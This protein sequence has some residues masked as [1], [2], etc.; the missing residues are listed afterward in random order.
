MAETATAFSNEGREIYVNGV[1]REITQEA[2]TEKFQEFGAIEKVRIKR[3]KNASFVFVLFADTAAANAAIEGVNGKDSLEA[4]LARP[5][6]KRRQ[7]RPLGPPSDTQLFVGNLPWSVQE[8][9][10]R[11][12]FSEFDADI[13]ECAIITR[14]QG[15]SRGFGFVSFSTPESASAA[16]SATDNSVYGE[17]DAARTLR[18]QPARQRIVTEKKARA[19]T[20]V[21]AA[22]ANSKNQVNNQV[23]CSQLPKNLTVGHLEGLFVDY[24]VVGK[25]FISKLGGRRGARTRFG[26]VTLASVVEVESAIEDLDGAEYNSE[27]DG[28]TV[29]WVLKVEKARSKKERPRA[30]PLVT[31]DPSFTSRRVFVKGFSS[32]ATQEDISDLFADYGTVEKVILKNKRGPAFAFVTFSTPD[33]AQ[34]AISQRND[35]EIDGAEGK[36]SVEA[37]KPRKVRGAAPPKAAAADTE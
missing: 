33:E 5:P 21:G 30:R 35:T 11:Q 1:E 34:E 31:E 19:S 9:E 23:Y 25:S 3:R 28:N 12:I 10:L 15:R 29:A 37:S 14:Q 17:G 8:Q 27:E 24:T 7:S 22:P 20:S 13:T 16:L 32:S 18:V 36:L 26:F 2:I 6:R 4:A